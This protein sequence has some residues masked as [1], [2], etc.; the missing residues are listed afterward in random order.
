M[1]VDPLRPDP[2][3]PPLTLNS[4]GNGPHFASRSPPLPRTPSKWNTDG[5]P[6]RVLT[7]ITAAACASTLVAPLITII[8]RYRTI[9]SLQTNPLAI[10]SPPQS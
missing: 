1:T 4:A 2:A 10:N 7:D 3:P 6:Q 5:L 8:D 9:F